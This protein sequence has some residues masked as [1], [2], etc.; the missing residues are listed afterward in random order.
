[1]FATFNQPETQRDNEGVLFFQFT[2]ILQTNGVE[3]KWDRTAENMKGVSFEITLDSLPS[4]MG[5]TAI[6]FC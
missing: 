5:W 1:M 3:K 6:K 2:C 4:A